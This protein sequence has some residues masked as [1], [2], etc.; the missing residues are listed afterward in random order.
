MANEILKPLFKYPGGKSSEYKYLKKLFPDFK[1]FVEPFLGGGAIYWA[2]KADSYLINDYSKELISI[3][4]FAQ[5]Q[6][7]K[8]LGLLKDI[9]IIWESKV[10][11]INFIKELIMDTED[12]SIIDFKDV[13]NRL[14]SLS[15][16]LP[17][18]EEQLSLFLEESIAR[19][20]KSLKRVA[21]VENIKNWDENAHGVIGASI[22]TY[23]RS[24]YNKTSYDQDPQLK[25]VL[26]LFLREY[27]YSSMFRY[28][29]SG[30]FNVPFGGNSYAKK[31]FKNRIDQIVSQD[32][33]D[34]LSKTEIR[35]GDFSQ[36]FIDEKDTFMFLDP[37]YDSEF[38]TYNLHVFDYKEQIRLRDN[39][40]KLKKTKWLMVIK[41]T[42]F[43]EELYDKDSWYKIH[44][45]KSYSVN[46]KNRNMQEVK[47]LV[48][49]NY[50]IGEI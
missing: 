1:H 49:T 32:V 34:K 43:I 11:Y 45:D 22:Y 27:S 38:S 47:H 37:P 6:D 13:S 39:L 2:T 46:F 21:K 20:K 9:S 29:A 12:S 16:Y 30:D 7:E 44:F 17:R 26:Y 31:P 4:S 18:K 5:A 3:Y 15:K 40:L 8:F 23:L 35:Q 24:L 36:A 41:S 48:I 25:T 10:Q 50:V 42:D 28:N 33:Y 19:K 14:L